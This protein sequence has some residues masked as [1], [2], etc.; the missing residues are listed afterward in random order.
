MYIGTIHIYLCQ[1]VNTGIDM[2]KNMSS[3]VGMQLPYFIFL[4]TLCHYRVTMKENWPYTSLEKNTLWCH[5]F[6]ILKRCVKTPCKT[7]KATFC[8][9]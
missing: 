5:V 4:F 3:I 8:L 7:L 6:S 9:H 1:C 2:Y